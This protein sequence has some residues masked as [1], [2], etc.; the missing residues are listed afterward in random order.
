[1]YDALMPEARQLGDVVAE[2]IERRGGIDLVRSAEADPTGRREVGE[3]LGSLGLWELDPYADL[4]QLEAA[5]AAC[6][7]AGRVALP[8]PVAGRLA[9][10]SAADVDA[11]AFVD[12]R[13][14]RIAHGDLD[15]AWLVC[16]TTRAARVVGEGGLLGGRLGPFAADVEA[17]AWTAEVDRRQLATLLLLEG[18][19][20]H[21]MVDAAARQTYRYVSEREQFGAPLSSFQGLRFALTEAE[22]HLQGLTETARYTLWSIH[23]GRDEAWS[24][25]LALRLTALE[26]AD[27]IF[28]IGHQAHGAMGLCDESDLSWLS[29]HSQALRRLPWGRTRTEAALLAALRE[30]PLAGPF[31]AA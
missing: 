7:A 13:A 16:D 12:A 10:T 23:A 18:W 21:G 9:A 3:L 20:L 11:L 14:P 19:T 26:A 29:R 17:G 27:A 15:L 25:A 4:T 2:A 28:R 31:S 22:V 5:A 24:D 30:T 6:H 8:Y 1:M